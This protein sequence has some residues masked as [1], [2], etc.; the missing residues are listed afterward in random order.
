MASKTGSILFNI[1][2][3]NVFQVIGSWL[4]FLSFLRPFKTILVLSPLLDSCSCTFRM[5]RLKDRFTDS[6]SL[7]IKLWLLQIM[8]VSERTILTV[9]KSI[10]SNTFYRREDC[11]RPEDVKIRF[12]CLQHEGNLLGVGKPYSKMTSK[13]SIQFFHTFFVIKYASNMQYI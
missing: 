1:T 7:G 11:R 4:F 3:D 2:M 10:L 12:F 6:S 5:I 13:Q 8:S 9:L